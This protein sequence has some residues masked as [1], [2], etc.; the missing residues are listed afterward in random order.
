MKIEIEKY[1]RLC[2]EFL[3]GVYDSDMTKYWFHLPVEWSGVF[4]PTTSDLKF[5]S[6]WN[7]IHE[8][9][10][11]ISTL[12][13]SSHKHPIKYTIQ[14]DF[15]LIYYKSEFDHTIVVKSV[16]RGDC[17]NTKESVVKAIDSFLK[18]YEQNK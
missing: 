18:W 2:A 12:T 8:V 7:W 15:C 5:D 10:E 16:R 9:L 11:K 13:I 4:A 17:N 3:G 1:N 6:D 14:K